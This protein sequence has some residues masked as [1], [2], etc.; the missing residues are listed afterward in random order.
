MLEQK[1]PVLTV[2]SM[3]A[4]QC[5]YNGYP[6]TA[7]AAGLNRVKLVANEGGQGLRVKHTRFLF[8]AGASHRKQ[9]PRLRLQ[10]P[11]L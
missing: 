7:A 10:K 8:I 1:A 11:L 4:M 3:C 9:T 5:V 2:H 6:G